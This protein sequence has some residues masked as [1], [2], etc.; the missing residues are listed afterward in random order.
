MARSTPP[1]SQARYRVLWNPEAWAEVNALSAFA[2]RPVRHAVVDLRHQAE[3]E[4]RNRKRL[5]EPLA[6][7]P[8]ATW[9]VRV[10]GRYRLLYCVRR[11][12]VEGV[13]IV[14]TVEI[15]RAIIKGTETTSEVLR[16]KP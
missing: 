13:N 5:L 8:D 12:I 14:P 2:R 4:T 11:D 15:L 7:L 16:R 3:V 1:G 9:E 6:E 10:Q